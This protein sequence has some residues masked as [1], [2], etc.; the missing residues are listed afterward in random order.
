MCLDA[1]EIRPSG[2][3][4]VANGIWGFFSRKHIDMRDGLSNFQR[5]IAHNCSNEVWSVLAVAHRHQG[6]ICTRA[7]SRQDKIIQTE[8]ELLITDIL[9]SFLSFLYRP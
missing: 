6:H 5:D 4:A 9:L 7:R 1:F 3:C 2:I 8:F